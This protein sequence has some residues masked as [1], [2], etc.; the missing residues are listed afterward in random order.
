MTG[1]LMSEKIDRLIL[2]ATDLERYAA[3]HVKSIAKMINTLANGVHVLISTSEN[4]NKIIGEIN[5]LVDNTFEEIEARCIDE[6]TQ[7]LLSE[8]E[9]ERRTYEEL[10]EQ[11]KQEEDSQIV[12]T[13]LSTLI[14]GETFRQSLSRIRLS[15]KRNITRTIKSGLADNLPISVIARQVRGTASR[16][17]RDGIYNSVLNNVSA[18][19]RTAITTYSNR[20][21]LWWWGKVDV[22]KYIW[23]SVLDNR[24]TAICRARSNK[25]YTVGE[26]PIPPAHYRCRSI[27]SRYTSG[28]DIP[29]SYGDWLRKQPR[30][31]VED[32]LG[33][34]KA[35]LFLSGK[36]TLDKFITPTGR[37]LTLKE[38][39]NRTSQ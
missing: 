25:T 38:L 36:L 35:K 8:V 31:V 15:V 19:A 22:K 39:L 14:L 23:I 12:G 4:P 17:Y 11:E 32:I 24:T 27:I 33:V 37:E 18:L 3:G 16:K 5:S 26:G 29:Q 10:Q 30:E 7:L 20:A 9:F 28:E 34:G 6:Y 1:V 21:R 2:R 13:L